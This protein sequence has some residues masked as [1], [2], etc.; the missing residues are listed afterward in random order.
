MTNPQIERVLA[1]ADEFMVKHA[2]LF[3]YD[4]LDELEK[5]SGFSKV[6]FVALFITLGVSSVFLVGGIGLVTNLISF[7]YPAFATLKALDTNV[8]A[9][10]DTQWSTY[11]IIF[12][13]VSIMEPALSFIV[14]FYYII[15]VAFF[16]WMFHPKF[17]GASFV[18]VHVIDP[19]VMP[20]ISS[21]EIKEVVAKKAE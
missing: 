11:W 5:K 2:S 12:T 15:K 1:N 3:H 20:H 19:L 10:R 13:L 7:L 21:P 16:G 8:G 18:Y 17:L 14:P 9:T 4:K 6:Y